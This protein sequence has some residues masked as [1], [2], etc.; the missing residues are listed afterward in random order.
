[1]LL[2][3]ETGLGPAEAI[4]GGAISSSQS[5]HAGLRPPGA[6][7]I[8]GWVAGATAAGAPGAA[9][10]SCVAVSWFAPSGGGPKST[11]R[12]SLLVQLRGASRSFVVHVAVF[13]SG[14][15]PEKP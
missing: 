12:T 8:L 9:T 11:H 1:M 5:A 10:A 7:C 4:D 15:R 2:L 6:G 3:F 13:P 14:E